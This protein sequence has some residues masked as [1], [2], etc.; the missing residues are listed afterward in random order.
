[1]NLLLDKTYERTLDRLLSDYSGA[2]PGTILEAWTFDGA[3]SRREA[4]RAFAARGIHA[5]LRSAYKPLIHFFLEEADLEGLTRV[6]VT[7]PVHPGCASDRFLLEAY[8]LSAL[9]GAVEVDFSGDGADSG[10]AP[11][12]VVCLSYSDGRAA[13]HR[14]LAPNREYSDHTGEAIVTPSGWLHVSL[15]DGGGTDERLE[16]DYEAIFAEALQTVANHPWRDMEPF[17]DVLSIRV[18]LPSAD[19]PLPVGEEAI[20]L[21]EALHE[22]LYFSLLEFFQV[23]TGRAVSDRTIRPGQVV[24]EI[25]DGK[26]PSLRI[27]LKPFSVQDKDG[28]FQDLD[29]AERPLAMAQVFSELDKIPGRYFH[30]ASF[31]GRVIPAKYHA[32]S[33]AAVMIS[34]GQH[35]N[36]TTGVVGALRAARELGL[37][38]GAHFA[39]TPL[40]NPDGYDL[41]RRLCDDNPRHMHHAARYTAQGNDLEYQEEYGLYEKALREEARRLSGADLHVNLHGYASHEWTRPLSGY[42]PR[43]FPTWMLPH[44][45]FLV[46]RHHEEWLDIARE[47]L[48]R[49]TLRLGE[50][51]GLLS[52][53]ESQLRLYSRYVKEPPF[54]VINGFPCELSVNETSPIPL[55]LI[56]EYPDETIYGSAFIAGHTAQME[57]VLAAYD[58]FQELQPSAPLKRETT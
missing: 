41:H 28:A 18:A 12:Y 49:L 34:G 14:V 30:A 8:P 45:F 43:G 58:V 27:E 4:E 40:E 36:E 46:L 50:V 24:P 21:K 25:S 47:F 57:T 7:Y 10:K 56:T 48:E 5:R 19:F 26:A 42:I 1:M 44:G 17:F 31:S 9:L 22:D 54:Q 29:A 20:S 16:T 15:P 35:A 32:G 39:V 37:R 2:A 51:P 33:D 55:R 11:T 23:K 38:P 53:T 52:F 3:E 13:T 6:D